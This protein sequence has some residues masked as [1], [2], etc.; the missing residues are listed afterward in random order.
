MP[1]AAAGTEAGG[2]LVAA[3]YKTLTDAIVATNPDY[4]WF[5]VEFLSARMEVTGRQVQTWKEA[6]D[7]AILW[8]GSAGRIAEIYGCEVGRWKKIVTVH[9]KD[10]PEGTLHQVF[11]WSNGPI[12]EEIAAE[13]SDCRANTVAVPKLREAVWHTLQQIR[14]NPDVAWH[15]GEGTETFALLTQAAALLCD[16]PLDAIRELFLPKK[17]RDAGKAWRACEEIAAK[18]PP[19]EE[20]KDCLDCRW[21]NPCVRCIA[22]EAIKQ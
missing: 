3:P 2:A 10:A 8:V 4:P 6:L 17:T 14:D 12:T 1:P 11:H 15:L 13:K 16:Q 19:L 21:G 18:F 7:A 22:A 20:G 9:W 5:E